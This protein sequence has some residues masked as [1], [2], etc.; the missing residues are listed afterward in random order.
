M[1]M[2]LEP[3]IAAI[4]RDLPG[5]PGFPA[6]M[7]D[8]PGAQIAAKRRLR[9]LYQPMIKILFICHCYRQSENVIRIISARKA[10]KPESKQYVER[11]YLTEKFRTET[12]LSVSDYIRKVKIHRAKVLLLSTDMSVSQISEKLAFNTPNYFIHVFK[13][14]EGCTPAVFRE[15]GQNINDIEE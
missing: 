10:T 7:Y 12:G 1:T 6:E 15:R 8:F 5:L 2:K 9:R 13:E 11:S 4:C 14:L 3:F